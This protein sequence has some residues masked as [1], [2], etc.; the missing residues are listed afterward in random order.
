M[1][2]IL[3]GTFLKIKRLTQNV[4]AD[5]IGFET[6]VPGD[7]PHFNVIRVCMSDKQPQGFDIRLFVYS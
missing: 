6:Q 3:I 7:T 1:C 5:A 4:W 2:R